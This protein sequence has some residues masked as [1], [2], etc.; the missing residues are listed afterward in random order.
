[1]GVGDDDDPFIKPHR[2]VNDGTVGTYVR[3]IGL[4]IDSSRG[5]GV[6]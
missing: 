5:R 4:Y 2:I 3:L 6:M 1:M